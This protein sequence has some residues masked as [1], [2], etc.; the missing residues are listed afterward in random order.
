LLL[1]FV[2]MVIAG[3]MY[4]DLRWKRYKSESPYVFFV[5]RCPAMPCRRSAYCTFFFFFFFFF[6]FFCFSC[7]F[8]AIGSFV[9]TRELFGRYELFRALV[10]LDLQNSLINLATACIYFS[11][12][13]SKAQE[14]GLGLGI[15]LFFVE[16]VFERTAA[17]AVR[18][19][20][21]PATYFF[22][23]L[24]TLL[25]A[26]IL[27]VIVSSAVTD[28][29]GGLAIQPSLWGMALFFGILTLVVRAF[30]VYYSWT[31]FRDFGEKYKGVR[32]LLQA[33]NMALQFERGKIR[34]VTGRNKGKNISR[35]KSQEMKKNAQAGASAVGA[36][37]ATGG[38]MPD[39]RRPSSRDLTGKT[40]GE[41]PTSVVRNPF[42]A[43]VDAGS[44]AQTP[45]TAASSTAAATTGAAE[46]QAVKSNGA[47]PT[48]TSEPSLT[49]MGLHLGDDDEAYSRSNYYLE[50]AKR[51]G[52]VEAEE[53]GEEYYE[54]GEEGE[55]GEGYYG[56]GDDGE[57]EGYEGYDYEEGHEKADGGGAYNEYYSEDDASP[58]PNGGG[59]RGA[60]VQMTPMQHSH[61]AYSMGQASV[62]PFYSQPSPQMSPYPSADDAGRGYRVAAIQQQTSPRAAPGAVPMPINR[63]Q[64]QQQQAANAAISRES[65]Y[66][67]AASATPSGASFNTKAGFTKVGRYGG[68]R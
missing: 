1:T 64:Q 12:L 18:N 60:V 17:V 21:R 59:G 62:S 51:K 54:D 46:G 22:W 4:G 56:E 42:V 41:R 40:A 2:S 33:D 7:H 66:G 14:V 34:Q 55:D 25:P 47:P 45:S 39:K 52:E 27:W 8:A 38:A 67:V 16:I 13:N 48:I 5:A 68:K 24:S 32:K 9:Q 63:S 61:S 3:F 11:T 36:A 58:H 10:S 49:G 26:Y 57:E 29:E 37:V 6:I 15:A 35:G 30:T 20:S 31:L 65:S 23:F 43:A 53:D 19:E 44:S 50:A 28:I